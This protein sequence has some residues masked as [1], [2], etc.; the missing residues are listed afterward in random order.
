L[1]LVHLDVKS[2]NV[3]VGED[4]NWDLGDFGSAVVITSDAPA[5]IRVTACFNPYIIPTVAKVVPA[6]DFVLLSVMIST[7][8]FDKDKVDNF[9]NVFHWTRELGYDATGRVQASLILKSYSRI[10]DPDFRQQMENFFIEN[11][12]KVVQHLGVK[13]EL[14]E[15][16]SSST[17]S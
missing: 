11:Y 5:R 14:F 12:K 3:F 16:S 4:G 2:H 7:E 8:L 1:N 13:D 15:E 6:M 10:S 17:E 9:D